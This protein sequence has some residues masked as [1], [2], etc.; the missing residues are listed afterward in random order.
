M[1][2]APPA[3]RWTGAAP[4]FANVHD[5]CVSVV[6]GEIDNVAWHDKLLA[7]TSNSK[8]GIMEVFG[9]APVGGGKDGG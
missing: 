5:A 2:I 1:A 8:L 3:D 4:R 9:S 6:Q 7:S